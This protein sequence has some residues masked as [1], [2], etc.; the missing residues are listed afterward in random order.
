MVGLEQER[1]RGD[2]WGGPK[3]PGADGDIAVY[4]R[5]HFL[6]WRVRVTQCTRIER[7][8]VRT[9]DSDGYGLACGEIA[10]TTS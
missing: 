2:K 4:E 8:S 10:P 7:K 3:A 9:D 1:H 6:G 5:I